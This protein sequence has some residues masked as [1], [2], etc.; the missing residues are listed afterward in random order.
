MLCFAMAVLISVISLA[1]ISGQECGSGTFNA[2]AVLDGSTWTVRN[3]GNSVYTGS[4]MLDA[5][6]K[7]VES[8][9]P[10][11]NTKERVVV[12]GSGSISANQSLDLPSYTIIDI[13]GT[14]N[15]EG[16][17]GG[18]NA[19]IRGRNVTEVEVQHIKVTGA[20]Y[21]GIFFRRGSNITLGEIDLRLSGGLGIRIDNDPSGVGDWGMSNR[22]TNV[23][24]DNVYV[25]G[26]DNH[27]V[28]TYGV[29]GITIGTV[30]ARNTAY[31]GLLL[32]AT[33]NATVGLVDAED[34]GTGSGYAAFRMA[35]RNGQVNGSYP[36]NIKVGEVRARRGGRGV[37]SVS[38]SGGAVI[39]RIDIADAGNNSILLENCYNTLIAA[40]SGTVTGGGEIRIAARDE[41]ANNRDITI[42]N[43]TVNN[44]GIKE[45]PCGENI[46]F[47]NITR[48][49]NSPLNICSEIINDPVSTVRHLSHSQSRL[50]CSLDESVLILSLE[51]ES[52]NRNVP[53]KLRVVSVQGRIIHEEVVY[54]A[55]AFTRRI[56]LTQEARGVYLVTVK[57]EREKVF[58]FVLQ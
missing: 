36:V 57:S 34:A 45:D 50:D 22:L 56:D 21:F 49:G 1:Q 58:R 24:I 52:T 35:N 12:R 7:A 47:R 14:I 54:R 40:E 42:Q 18:D 28:E 39:D 2:E 41:F 55:E 20:P 30:T 4:D 43:L 33:I 27:G 23:H 15:V 31:C 29:D 44:T 3:G 25:S 17:P 38:E 51:P 37:F 32:N 8:L 46:V 11:R 5:M 6:R 48:T 26:T 10:G 16:S 19:V 9:T 53:V 13:C